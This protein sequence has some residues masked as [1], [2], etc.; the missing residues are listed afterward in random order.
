VTGVVWNLVLVHLEI[1]L[2]SS[3]D[4]SVGCTE[5]NIGIEIVWTHS[6]GL[7]CDKAQVEARF[8]PFGDSATLDARLVHGLCRTYRGLG[9]SIGGTRW[10]CKVTWVMWNLVSICFGIVLGDSAIHDAR[11][12]HCLHCMYH[13]L[14]NSFGHTRWNS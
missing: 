12:L 5:N 2:V 6:M 3:K 4:R 10:N 1:V 13:R 9:N 8:G 11:Y 14:I 7:L